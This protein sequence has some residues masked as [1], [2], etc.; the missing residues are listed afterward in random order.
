M[1]KFCSNCG[2]ELGEFDKVCSNCGT[3]V[4]GAQPNV[5][6][7]PAPGNTGDYTAD[8]IASGKVMALISY[9]GIL[10]LVPYFA[11]KNNRYVRFH[12]IQGINFFIWDIILGFAMPFITAF[13]PDLIETIASLVISIG[14]IALMVIGI[15]NAC[16]GKAKELPVVSSL[17]KFV[18]E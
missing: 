14:L 4:G 16:E 8:E 17:P 10:S 7:Q 1:S 11:E 15:V 13:L 12:A 6:A 5:A 3:P 18:K 9:I 2:N